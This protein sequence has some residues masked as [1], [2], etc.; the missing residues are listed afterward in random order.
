MKW[1][2][3][4]LHNNNNDDDNDNNDNNN[5]KSDDKRR[6][7]RCRLASGCADLVHRGRDARSSG[8][9]LLTAAVLL[10]SRAR[11]RIQNTQQRSA[12]VM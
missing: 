11:M 1:C 10:W 4:D 6:C 8:T 9:D 12:L 5:N 3:S 2:C 7:V